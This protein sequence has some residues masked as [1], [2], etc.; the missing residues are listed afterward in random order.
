MRGATRGIFG[1]ERSSAR[2]ILVMR[3]WVLTKKQCDVRLTRGDTIDLVS[4]VRLKRE[5]NFS[6]Y[7]CSI[8]WKKIH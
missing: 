5:I 7:N 1:A 3:T 4:A 2:D 8:L 6:L